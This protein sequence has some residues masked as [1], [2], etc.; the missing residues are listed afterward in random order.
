MITSSNASTFKKIIA[1]SIGVIGILMLMVL[2][3]LK[4]Q[5]FILTGLAFLMIGISIFIYWPSMGTYIG[6]F[7]IHT[8]LSV[9]M[10]KF[11]GVPQAA[12]GATWLTI[13]IPFTIY[14]FILRKKVMIDYT[15][16]IMIFFLMT[17]LMSYFMAV[18]QAMASDWIFTYF[19]EGMVLYFFILNIIRD[20]VSMR[21]VVWTLMLS[22]TLLGSLTLFQEVTKSYDNNFMGLAQ[23]QTAFGTE[24]IPG[25]DTSGIVKERVKVR[26]A[27]RADGPIG[28]PNRFSQIMLLIFPLVMFRVWDEKTT[29]MKGLA[30]V[31]TVLTLCGIF[32]TYSRG[33]FVTLCF[34]IALMTLMRYIK[35]GQVIATVTL[36]L[37]VVLIAS[38]GYFNRMASIGGIEGLFS[39]EATHETDTVILSR[40]TEMLAAF[41][42][43]LDY[44]VFG[45]G[46]NQYTRHYSEAYM[47][48]PDIAFK[49]MKSTRAAHSLYFQ[50]LAELGLLGFSGFM[51]IIFYTLYKLMKGRMFW[52]DKDSELANFATGCMLGIITYLTTS[53]FLSFA[54]HRYIFMMVAISGAVIQL[55]NSLKIEYL[56]KN[57]QL[58]DGVE[59]PDSNGMEI[60]SGQ[61]PKTEPQ[62]FA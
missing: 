60:N 42:V 21:N 58:P 49:H 4:S 15:F 62:M 57:N 46:P 43:F 26:R 18:D 53:I 30:L 38:P 10:Y 32:L 23:R 41:T 6:L 1:A 27:H 47:A 37:T 59:L 17:T 14:V 55:L 20:R 29:L 39:S 12:A 48:N 40:T 16:V 24:E 22:G 2:S 50:M 28:D 33:A 44:P 34:I 36:L 35:L 13:G 8:N 11:H 56:A 25:G 51:M 7:V 31:G 3:M 9:I 54:Y 45:V 19:I 52:K 5:P 61:N